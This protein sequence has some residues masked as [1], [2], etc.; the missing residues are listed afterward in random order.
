[1]QKLFFE[2]GSR[3][4]L[5]RNHLGKIVS[6]KVEIKQAISRYSD[7]WLVKYTSTNITI[8]SFTGKQRLFD[9]EEIIIHCH[10]MKYG[11]WSCD[12]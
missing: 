12:C 3:A 6:S 8:D 5:K 2:Q 7:Q 9:T 4:L 11:L 10:K 1:M